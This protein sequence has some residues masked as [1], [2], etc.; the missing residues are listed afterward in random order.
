MKI[1]VFIL[2]LLV[3]AACTQTK[4]A[5]AVSKQPSDLRIR[6]DALP[7]K[8]L[9]DEWYQ[10]PEAVLLPAR[11]ADIS[12]AMAPPT[13]L[14]AEQLAAKYLAGGP[15]KHTIAFNMPPPNDISITVVGPTG[16]V[17]LSGEELQSLSAR[18]AAGLPA[19]KAQA[20]SRIIEH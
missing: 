10:I 4:D 11:W 8:P 7:E 6:I 3:P 2:V 20:L 5:P 9:P 18:G 1:L 12:A 14:S 15:F 13:R 16:F 17:S 19:S